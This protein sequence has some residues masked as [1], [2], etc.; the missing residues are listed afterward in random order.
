L[1]VAWSTEGV[2]DSQ[3]YRE[4]PYLKKYQQQINKQ[5]TKNNYLPRIH[6]R[7]DEVQLYI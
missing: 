3:S 7:S 1:R 2:P 5:Q 6:R 4:K